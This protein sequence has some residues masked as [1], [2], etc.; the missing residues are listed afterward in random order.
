MNATG[1]TIV[2]A[3][4]SGLLFGTGLLISGM[5][6]PAK[7]LGFLGF[8]GDW[9]ARLLFVMGGAI[10]VNAPL[11][12]WI[13]RRRT[14]LLEPS[15]RIPSYTAR[16]HEQIDAPLVLG[17]ALFGVGWGLAGYC[18]GPAIVSAASFVDGHVRALVF[19]L[20]MIA[21]MALFTA[22][23]RARLGRLEGEHTNA[24]LATREP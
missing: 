16:W 19:I 9:D 1:K 8:F 13:L 21:G 17:S 2:A 4:V 23:Q 3:A 7:V 22:W 18:P 6:D 10:A 20:S 14:P 5:T 15:F 11:T 24:D 12:W